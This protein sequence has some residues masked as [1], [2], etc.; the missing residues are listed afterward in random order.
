MQNP[1]EYTWCPRFS[2][3][4][5]TG[6]LWVYIFSFQFFQYFPILSHSMTWR[7]CSVL[8]SSGKCDP[9]QISRALRLCDSLLSGTLTCQ[10][11]HFDCTLL[12]QTLSFIASIQG[13]HSAWAAPPCSTVLLPRNYPHAVILG[14]HRAHLLCFH[15][16][17]L[18]FSVT[19]LPWVCVVARGLSRLRLPDFSCCEAQL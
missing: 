18:T 16:P 11:S 6:T 4:I 7:H 13:V 2:A 17:G 9:L 12:L 15:L 3:L 19:W 8:S 1:P 10:S 5:G 14:N